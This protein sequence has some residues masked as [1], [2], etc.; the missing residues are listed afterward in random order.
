[1]NE[2][3]LRDELRHTPVDD[4]ARGR[5]LRVVQAAW[6]EREPVSAQR[7]W[8]PALAVAACLLLVV[9]AVGSATAPG[10]A[11]ARWV[12]EVLGGGRGPVRD[13]VVLNAAAG[14]VSFELAKDPAQVQRAILDRFRDKMAVAEEAIDSGAAARKLE[15]WVAATKA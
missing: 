14:L 7:R 13:I 8:A 2:Q 10:D 6:T 12:S 9:V 1:M 15:D 3:R 11:V 5:A 4:G